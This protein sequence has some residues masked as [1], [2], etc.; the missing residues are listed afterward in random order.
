M[1]CL[2]QPTYI[3]EILKG[4]SLDLSKIGFIPMVYWKHLSKFMCPKTQEGRENMNRIPY[5]SVI[6]LIIYSMIYMLE[7]CPRA[8]VMNYNSCICTSLFKLIKGIS[9][10]YCAMFNYMCLLI[11]NNLMKFLI[12][13]IVWMQS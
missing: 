8:I 7:I 6:G 2:S 9:S 5:T 13:V 1:L 12:S 4:F 10:F 3:E 11:L